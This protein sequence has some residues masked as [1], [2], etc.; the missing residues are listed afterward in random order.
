MDIQ[1]FEHDW[2]GGDITDW[3]KPLTG[4]L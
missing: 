1:S 2:R 4:L 3:S